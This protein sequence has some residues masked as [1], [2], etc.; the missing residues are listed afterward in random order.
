[1]TTR[2]FCLLLSLPLL[3]FLPLSVTAGISV[4][5]THTDVRR[6]V[7]AMSKDAGEVTQSP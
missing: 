4:T 2:T 5:Y 7:V 1:M 6:S 3:V